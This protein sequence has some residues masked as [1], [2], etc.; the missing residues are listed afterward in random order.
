MVGAVEFN[1]IACVGATLSVVVILAPVVATVSLTAADVTARVKV[2]GTRKNAFVEALL[3]VVTF[4]D[5]DLVE[6]ALRD[7]V[8][9]PT[10]ARADVTVP[11]DVMVAIG[12]TVV[13]AAVVGAAVS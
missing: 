6:F 11:I 7:T 5:T 9:P 10:T 2:L 4:P 1:A 13:L 8:D 3:V 12:A